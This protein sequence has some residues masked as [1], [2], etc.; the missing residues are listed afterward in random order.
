MEMTSYARQ[1]QTCEYSMMPIQ[2]SS[3][4][5]CFFCLPQQIPAQFSQEK[6]GAKQKTMVPRLYTKYNK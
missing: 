3:H 2:K 5:T 1:D 6:Y 4:S